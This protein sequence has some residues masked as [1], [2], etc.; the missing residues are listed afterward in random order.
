MLPEYIVVRYQGL[1]RTLGD[2]SK[3]EL[4]DFIL[5]V[6]IERQEYVSYNND[7]FDLVDELK[8]AEARLKDIAQIAET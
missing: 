5:R 7:W 2:L 1:S 6:R 8:D 4:I 3:E